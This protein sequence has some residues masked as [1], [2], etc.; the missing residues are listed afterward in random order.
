MN[1]LRAQNAGCPKNRAESTSGYGA[2]N[3]TSTDNHPSFRLPSRSRRR[4]DNEKEFSFSFLVLHFVQCTGEIRKCFDFLLLFQFFSLSSR[5]ENMHRI[6]P[7]ASRFPAKQLAKSMQRAIVLRLIT[8]KFTFFEF[9]S[10]GKRV[11]TRRKSEAR[12]QSRDFIEKK[13]CCMAAQP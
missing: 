13:R 12:H 7:L 5:N 11:E 10:C 6:S 8:P 9:I 3:L 4:P 1:L 2:G